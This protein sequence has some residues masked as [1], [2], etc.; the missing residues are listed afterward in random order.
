MM[1][2][3]ILNEKYELKKEIFSLDAENIKFQ[4]A[5]DINT[6]EEFEILWIRHDENNALIERI[7]RGIKP[8]IDS[9]ID[10]LQKIIDAGK[11]DKNQCYF[12]VYEHLESSGS[13]WVK[14]HFEQIIDTLGALK[15]QN[16]QGL[17]LNQDTVVITQN[18]N[19]KIRFVGLFELFQKF[20]NLSALPSLKRKR[21]KDDIKDLALLFASFLTDENGK[22]IHEKCING[23]YEKYS[24][25]TIDVDK[26]PHLKNPDYEDIQIVGNDSKHDIDDVVSELNKGCYWI[27]KPEKS[28]N[29]DIEIDWSTNIISGKFYVQEEKLCGTLCVAYRNKY[30]DDKILTNSQKER[31]FFNFENGNNRDKHYSIDYFLDKIVENNELAQLNETKNDQIKI[32]RTLPEKEKEYIEELAFKAHYTDRKPVKNNH[33]NIKFFLTEE[34]KDWERVKDKKN[35]GIKLSLYDKDRELNYIGKIQDYDPKQHTLIVKDSKLS[36]KEI[37]KQGELI[38]D[39]SQETSQYKKQIEACNKLKNKDMVNPDLAGFLATPEVM[40][41]NHIEIDDDHFAEKIIS[42]DLRSDETQKQAVIA[43]L[44]RKPIYLIQGPPGTGKTTVIVEL[45]QQLVMQKKDIKILVVSQSN[46]AV[47]N[48]LQRLPEEILFMRLISEH[49]IEHDN[50]NLEIQNHLFGTKLK[51]WI[52]ETVERSEKH[53]KKHYP[54]TNVNFLISLYKKYRLNKIDD[55]KGFQKLYRKGVARNHF[56]KLFGNVDRIE[57]V[58]KI[59]KNELGENLITLNDL[60][61]RWVAFIRNAP[62]KKNLCTL[63]NGSED[64]DLQ[65]A[66][67][68]S[69]NVFGATCIHIAN[70]KYSKINFK[71]DYMI[72]D[73]ASKA[74]AAEAMVPI[75]MSQNLVLI[76]DHKQLPPV[77]TREK[78][79]REKVKDELEDEG[80][81]IDK[82]YGESL[83]EQLYSRFEA[84]NTFEP[85]K[86][87]LDIQYR[88]PRQLG[89]LISKH[90][91]NGELKNPDI[92]RLPNYDED[93]SHQL[94]LKKPIIRIGDNEEVPSSILFISTSKEKDPSDNDKKDKRCNN[95]NI[96]KIKN[97]LEY[98]NAHYRDGK[99]E[100]CLE[101]IGI[102]AAYRGQVEL[103]K[104]KVTVQDYK[105]FKIDI[106]T[107]DKF[108]GSERDVIIY[109]IVRSSDGK[110]SI[111]FLDDFRR[112]NVA[113]SRARKLLIV[114]GD[115]EYLLKRATPNPHSETKKLVL[116]SITEELESWGCIYNSIEEAFTNDE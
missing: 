4:D 31:A 35:D 16:R 105:K 112:I 34:F 25:L 33:N 42:P 52:N 64:I 48:V 111:G 28:K 72:M 82:T 61:D 56:E 77:I 93:K 101:N 29:D 58:E 91:Y 78:G 7:I 50:I 9:K 44:H 79:V 54:Q 40:P 49:A 32:W 76:G 90:I 73:E 43:A 74:T 22:N 104:Q 89:A 113:F 95:C 66:F 94:P 45:V 99:V 14:Y 106:N 85:Y 116:K 107:V 87:M 15:K 88:M 38:E 86:I 26:L 81:D 17:I 53:I 21:I 46:M 8:L 103:L 18:D 84:E 24:E 65:I 19:I 115:S 63:K 55:I 71:F 59:F 39:V 5:E 36:I 100:K 30:S 83:F 13:D 69:M 108:Q 67:A 70:G 3:I 20:Q 109:D 57:K 41:A 60:H 96:E 110:S 2:E 6:G 75:T 68:K 98:L 92:K 47:D 62:S 1:S 102:I 27:I 97:I 37:V 23:E 12:I 51:T 80:L 10:G 11:D 114:V